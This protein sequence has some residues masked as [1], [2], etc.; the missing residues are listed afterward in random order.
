MRG[1]ILGGVVTEEMVA[2]MRAW[3]GDDYFDDNTNYSDAY[4]AARALDPAFKLCNDKLIDA[5][6]RI[7]ELERAQSV[8]KDGS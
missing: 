3:V 5:N 8:T 7:N 2:A 6:L 1:I 4:L